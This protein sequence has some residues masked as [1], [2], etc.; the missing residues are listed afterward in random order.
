MFDCFDTRGHWKSIDTMKKYRIHE[1]DYDFSG[2]RYISSFYIDSLEARAMSSVI[3]LFLSNLVKSVTNLSW[4]TGLLDASERL[5]SSL[6][7]QSAESW[8]HRELDIWCVSISKKKVPYRCKKWVSPVTT[9]RLP[10]QLWYQWVTR[11][12]DTVPGV[13]I[14]YWIFKWTCCPAFR[15]RSTTSWWVRLSVFLL[16]TA[17]ILSPITKD[18]LLYKKV[19]IIYRTLHEYI[20]KN[21]AN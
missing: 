3:S 17:K 10:T 7:R 11:G 12:R 1:C 4:V 20:I 8:E 18:S 21:W 13:G 5:R 16:F 14:L 15:R 2:F 19:F 9:R 6:I